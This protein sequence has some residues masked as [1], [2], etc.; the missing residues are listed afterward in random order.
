MEGLI[1]ACLVE[2][3]LGREWVWMFGTRTGVLV[4]WSTE[5]EFHD[6]DGWLLAPARTGRA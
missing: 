3:L 4:S 5:Q 1:H 2:P 6:S